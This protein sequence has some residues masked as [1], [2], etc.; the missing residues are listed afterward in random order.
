[1]NRF[2]RSIALSLALTV[3]ALGC[4]GC[5]STA[6]SRQA[7]QGKEK[8][9]AYLRTRSDA[10][11]ASVVTATT[12]RVRPA[13]D[14]IDMTE[15]VFGKYLLDG[16]EYAYWVNTETGEIFTDER[17]AEFRAACYALLLSE[18]GLDGARCVGICNADFTRAPRTTVMPAEIV[19][20]EGYARSHIHSDE[21]SL[22]LWL[23]CDASEAP[24]NRWT[25][26][27][28]AD[29]NL[30]KARICVMPR[31]E[32]LPELGNGVNLGFTF[33]QNFE[34]DKYILSGGAA[35]FTPRR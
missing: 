9:E 30:D 18:L 22:S 31:G 7:A 34:G 11:K 3:F 6:E 28:T 19:D 32:A 27:D 23:V 13:P 2:F 33:F 21:F 14:Q 10:K 1:M 4:A 20:P 8:M 16:Q 25:A 5:F 17:C 12:D 29:W 15:F 35:E 26:E 24:P